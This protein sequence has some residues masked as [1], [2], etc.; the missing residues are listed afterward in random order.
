VRSGGE[1]TETLI[2]PWDL[3]ARADAGRDGRG[4]RERGICQNG[5]FNLPLYKI[6]RFTRQKGCVSL[7]VR[8]NRSWVI[9]GY[10][11]GGPAKPCADYALTSSTLAVSSLNALH[12]VF[13]AAYLQ[14]LRGGHWRR[15]RWPTM[16]TT[17]FPGDLPHS[18]CNLSPVMSPTL[19]N[20][21]LPRRMCVDREW[22]HPGARPSL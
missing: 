17:T 18:L 7:T 1:R 3:G 19:C 8:Q 2:P 4:S 15:T 12:S 9:L 20:L 10:L 16:V 21:I 22:V 14:C 11:A 6:H 5:S 13:A